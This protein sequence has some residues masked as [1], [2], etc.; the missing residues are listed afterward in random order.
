[1]LLATALMLGEGLGE[2]AAAVTLSSALGRTAFQPAIPSTRG[3]ADAVL[4]ELP[5]ALGVEFLQEAV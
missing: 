5:H 1:M 4:A 2:R 3:V